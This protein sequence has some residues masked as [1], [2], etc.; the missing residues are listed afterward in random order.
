ML[1]VT[2]QG[3]RVQGCTR[4][5][6]K[7]GDGFGRGDRK[8]GE[9]TITLFSYLYKI[10]CK[11]LT[12]SKHLLIL[13]L[14]ILFS[15]KTSLSLKLVVTGHCNRNT[16]AAGSLFNQLSKTHFYKKQDGS[17][18]SIVRFSV[19]LKLILVDLTS[20]FT[21]HVFLTKHQIFLYQCGNMVNNLLIKITN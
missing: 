19:C 14:Q 9:I 8:Y 10:I 15:Q 21:Q 2:E 1:T 7:G 13:Q 6:M 17:S 18:N 4:M 5:K 16:S 12:C 20:H 11:K 3:E